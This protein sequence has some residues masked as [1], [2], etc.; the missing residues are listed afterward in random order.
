MSAQLIIALYILQTV[1]GVIAWR[2]VLP[3][4]DPP[5]PIIVMVSSFIIPNL[6]FLTVV[7]VYNI[8]RVIR[9][10]HRKTIKIINFNKI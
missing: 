10:W 5:L 3:K 4:N 6:I 7:I 8:W 1:L 9:F 2:K